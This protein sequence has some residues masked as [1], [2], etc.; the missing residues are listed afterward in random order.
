MAVGVTASRD[1][2]GTSHSQGIHN[3]RSG[4]GF[5][6]Q[7]VTSSVMILL[8]DIFVLEQPALM[9]QTHKSIPLI[10]QARPLE[11]HDAARQDAN[12]RSSW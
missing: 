8:L 6:R 2:P 9:K 10:S 11:T 5:R 12:R 3:G 4:P 1:R 7:P